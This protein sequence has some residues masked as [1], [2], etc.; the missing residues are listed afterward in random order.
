MPRVPV[1]SRELT[2]TRAICYVIDITP[3]GPKPYTKTL[4]CGRVYKTEEPLIA[5]LREIYE[6]DTFK[7]AKVKSFA[8]AKVRAKQSV[9][10]YVAHA[11]IEEIEEEEE[12]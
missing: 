6:S 7:I 9:E 10:F 12:A 5:S 2:V 8:P 1:V 3:K 4:Y 11:E